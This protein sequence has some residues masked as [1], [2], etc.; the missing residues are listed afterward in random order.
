MNSDDCRLF[1]SVASDKRL[2][3]FQSGLLPEKDEEWHLLIPSG[4][5]N[6]ISQSEVQRQST[7]FELIKWERDY[8][9]GLKLVQEVG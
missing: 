8:C 6:T 2:S 5:L 3:D 1:D 4:A 9:A 7:L